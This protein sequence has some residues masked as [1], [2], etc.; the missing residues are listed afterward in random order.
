MMS[1]KVSL[2]TWISIKLMERYM[3]RLNGS[4]QFICF[5]QNQKSVKYSKHIKNNSLIF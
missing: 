2:L 4:P 1:D 3:T 5:E